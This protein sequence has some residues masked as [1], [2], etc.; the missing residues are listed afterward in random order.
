VNYRGV[1][2]MIFSTLLIALCLQS[3]LASPDLPD[4]AVAKNSI[5]EIQKILGG[6]LSPALSSLLSEKDIGIFWQTK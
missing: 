6:D 2:S 1:N 3:V 4:A 5:K